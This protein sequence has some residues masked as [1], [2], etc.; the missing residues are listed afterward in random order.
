MTLTLLYQAVQEFQSQIASVAGQVLEQ[1][2]QLYGAAFL[3]GAKPLD[4]TTQEQRKTQLLGELNYSGKY[5]AFKEQMKVRRW[6][7]SGMGKC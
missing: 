2:Q 7:M 3:P 4:P 6:D 5:F 1:Y